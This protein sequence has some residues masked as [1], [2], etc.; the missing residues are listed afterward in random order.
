MVVCERY[1]EDQ[2]GQDRLAFEELEPYD[3]KLSRTVL[4]GQRGREAP[5]L[6][7]VKKFFLFPWS[8][9]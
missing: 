6:P 4:R 9:Y 5:A 2:P 7:D 3:G 1:L 8:S